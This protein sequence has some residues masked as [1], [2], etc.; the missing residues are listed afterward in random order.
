M[1]K[2]PA[3][4]PGSDERHAAGQNPGIAFTHHESRRSG[5]MAARLRAHTW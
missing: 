2:D 3:S 5:A 4:S 1:S